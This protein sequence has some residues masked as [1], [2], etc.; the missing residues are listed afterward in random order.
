MAR[1][2]VTGANGYI[3][4][5]IVERLVQMEHDVIACDF[6][7]TNLPKDVQFVDVDIF[8]T[9]DDLY[10]KLGSPEFC[11]HLAW[12][13]GFI[14]DSQ[15]H[16]ENLHKHYRFLTT[17]M[18]SGLVSLSVMGTMHE[19]GYWEGEIS[20]DTPCNP[21]NL[22]GIAKNALR[23]SLMLHS[24]RS[25]CKIH[26]LRAYYITGDGQHGK[27]IFSKISEAVENGRTEFPF[28]SGV[29]QYDFID[30]DELANMIIKATLQTEINGVIECCT[31]KPVSLGKKVSEYI[32][33]KGYNI[34]LAYGA[35]PDRKYDSP[36]VWGDPSKINL[37][38]ER[39]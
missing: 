5:H 10:E 2:L 21:L 26:W 37:I 28:T 14:H 18:E 17:M 30:I 20:A 24:D 16:L 6:K 38:M 31:G 15:S 27:N 4:V 29:N 32:E 19:V 13:D 39:Q 7:N 34:K 9:D 11:I 36:C 33:Q 35:F 8:S 25:K 1:I 12:K 22:Y 23:Q 3:G